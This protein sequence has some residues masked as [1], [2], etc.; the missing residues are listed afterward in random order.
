LN[1]NPVTQQQIQAE[2]TEAIQ[3]GSVELLDDGTTAMVYAQSIADVQATLAIARTYR[4]PVVP[5]GAATSLTG[6]SDGLPH[7]IIL[8]VQRMNQILEINTA[9]QIA[10][11]QPG[12][13]NGDLDAKVRELGYFYAPDPGSK[14]LSSIGGNVATNAGGMSSLKYGTTKQAVLGLTV[15]LANGDVLK[16]GGRVL[17]NAATYN[18]TDLFIGSEGTLGIIVEITVR[19]LP[20][21]LGKPLT[22]IAAFD[23]L[24][25]LGSAVQ[26][27]QA[28]GVYPSMLEA[29]NRASIEALAAYGH[30]DFGDTQAALIFQL[31]MPTPET[32]A[33]VQ[34]VLTAHHA[35]HTTLT[36][37]DTT[38]QRLIKI[39]QDAYA[40]DVAYGDI[41]VED[42]AVPLSQLTTFLAF[43]DELSATYQQP[44]FIV[45]HAGDGNIHPDLVYDR[46]LSQ[47]PEA[48]I[49]IAKKLFE[50]ALALQG[51]ITAEHGIGQFKTGWVVNQLD[52]VADQL[53][54]QIKSLLDPYHILNPTRKI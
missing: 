35:Q 16:T 52:P 45:G 27:L 54:H 21:P 50:K 10:R 15:V 53:Q 39:R 43:V 6:S 33:T 42:I 29:I 24:A 8:S 18:L 26:A 36:D 19:I 49:I 44:I 22:G 3:D 30:P 14:P 17:K 13:I 34:Q 23:T 48:L 5:Q 1:I 28:S 46:T 37:D 25:D 40:A 11:V 12:V 47:P 4:L 2:I 38:T 31:D 7:A 9:D 20:I 51:T 41:I 32:L